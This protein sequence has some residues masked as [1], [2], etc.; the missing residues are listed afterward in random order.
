[1][2][3]SSIYPIHNTSQRLTN[4][5][6]VISNGL[7]YNYNQ[8]QFPIIKTYYNGSSNWSGGNNNMYITSGH[9]GIGLYRED[10][11]TSGQK[12]QAVFLHT[13][14]ISYADPTSDELSTAKIRTLVS[15]N[16]SIDV[17]QSNLNTTI[18]GYMTANG[19]V[20]DFT[21]T[22]STLLN[23][24][25][26]IG[27]TTSDTHYIT[28]S[29]NI[30]GSLLLN[31]STIGGG[32]TLALTGSTLYTNTLTSNVAP[33]ESVIIGSGSG[34]NSTQGYFV[35]VGKDAG[36][37]AGIPG[38]VAIGWQ[39]G[40]AST[41]GVNG[42]VIIGGNAGYGASGNIGGSLIIGSAAGYN[43]TGVYGS[44]FLGYQAGAYA[45]GANQSIFIGQEA[46]YY[47]QNTNYNVHLGYQAGKAAN[48]GLAVG[49]NNIIIGSNVTLPA[50]Q[51][52]SINLGGTIFAT[53]IYSNINTMFSGSVQ[54]AKVGIATRTPNYT[55][56]VSGS[57]NF[58]NGLTISGSI[59]AVSASVSGQ[60][61]TNISDTFTGTAAVTKIVSLSSAEYS[62]LS[63]KDANT[64]Y[65][66]I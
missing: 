66:V 61:I 39:A 62:S 5:D 40:K 35:L 34:Y 16:V 17:P 60:V 4:F 1:M 52:D 53:G 37:N 57:G 15:D 63:P 33:D 64:L 56:D 46:G 38:T 31:G 26:S 6:N 54:T 28:G 43:A 18:L 12:L 59:T 14:Q 25:V 32:T 55:L 49:N 8:S 41:S 58:A 10:I 45:Q 24:G 51:S 36:Q 44:T 21:V 9:L 2:N 27:K 3:I 19:R 22:G 23:G 20:H 42:P 29:V 65:I 48:S 13:T 30:S 11:N 50:G 7:G 47:N